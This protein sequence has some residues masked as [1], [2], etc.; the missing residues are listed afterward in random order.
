MAPEQPAFRSELTQHQHI[1][2][3]LRCCLRGGCSITARGAA[4]AKQPVQEDQRTPLAQWPSESDGSDWLA[5]AASAEARLEGPPG[6]ARP[7]DAARFPGARAAQ[8]C[9]S[10]GRPSI[11]GESMSCCRGGQR[12]AFG[13]SARVSR[14]LQSLEL[15]DLTRRLR[16]GRSS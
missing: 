13:T 7:P 6:G 15:T 5:S 8:P 1:N 16:A 3:A 2:T 4:Q 12:C 10:R 14:Y 11:V 9:G